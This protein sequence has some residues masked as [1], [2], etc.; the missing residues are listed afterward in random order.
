[1][2]HRM[3]TTRPDR[4][5]R[6]AALLLVALLMLSLLPAASKPVD[7]IS[8]KVVYDDTVPNAVDPCADESYPACVDG[9]PRTDEMLFLVQVAAAYWASIFQDSHLYDI[10]V[11]WVIDSMPS[12]QTTNIDAQGRPTSAIVR[13]PA[14]MSFW[15]DPTPF[16]DEE[17]D[18][19][20][21]LYRDTH[22]AEQAEAFKGAPP[23]IFE[24]GYN[25]T[26]PGGDL[27]TILLH[28]LGHA[29]GMHKNVAKAG[30]N[31]SC[32]ED[33]NLYYDLDPSMLGGAQMSLK[34]YE[35]FGTFDLVDHGHSHGDD[36]HDR[37]RERP[38][39]IVSDPSRTSHA[40][41][42][43][44]KPSLGFD[45]SHLALGGIKA[46]DGDSECQSHQALMWVGMLPNARARPSIADILA[47]A[48]AAGWQEV[49]L[50]RKY[51]LDSGNWTDG[52]TWLGTRVPNAGNN[53][54]IINR[55]DHVTVN[56]YNLGQGR[57]VV[58]SDGNDLN[59]IFGTLD[60]YR[61][62]MSDH[63]T[64]L[65]ADSGALIDVVYLSAG[66][67]STIDLAN[68]ATVD[69]FWSVRS[70]GLLR[71][72]GDSVLETR[73]F[74][75]RGT[76]RANGGVFTIRAKTDTSSLDLDGKAEWPF[77]KSIE[78]LAG[79][80][81]FDGAIADPVNAAVK[82]GAG[83][84][85]SFTHGWQQ[86]YTGDIANALVLNGMTADAVVHGDTL[87]G[88]Y[89]VVD[90]R[91]RF[92][93]PVAFQPYA[94]RVQIDIDGLTPVTGH[95]Q[96]V[97]EQ[98]VEFSGVLDLIVGNQGDGGQLYEFVL[99]TPGF[100]PQPNDEFVI[101]TYASHSGAF[102]QING[103]S[104]GSLRLYPE[105]GETELRIVARLIGDVSGDG[106]LTNAD[107]SAL[108]QSF[109]PCEPN[110]VPC[111]GD[112]NADGVIDQQDLHLLNDMLK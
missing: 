91:G 85:V 33:T 30:R 32:D 89:V 37:D 13:V 104:H 82:I 64:T 75:N 87:L 78:A 12:A 60:A 6:V 51:S 41:G 1:M 67:G 81:V 103:W 92:T 29:I 102:Q 44:D 2:T 59:V 66:P 110:P 38:G 28:E 109:G 16:D 45:C 39:D 74:E 23:E 88:G 73:D 19:K 86:A 96:I 108:A 42:N 105:Y 83:Y 11:A 40:A 8:I 55:D 101:M 22:P 97:F 52:N 94:G 70:D 20:P 98:S 48:V 56:L 62:T 69:A 21:R 99:V 107:K 17:F 53:V 15:Y 7:A 5:M 46:C 3:F 76:I 68:G 49:H 58:I 47:I 50:P 36:D 54:Y 57:D 14:N 35:M 25:G 31:P 77:T 10:R 79:H 18:M 90:G 4:R 34:A 111:V 43:I 27:L 65:L 71:G 84:S 100:V 80:L 72:G 9:E 24:V 95:D 93:S 63:G 61:V 106:Q 112:I 26:G